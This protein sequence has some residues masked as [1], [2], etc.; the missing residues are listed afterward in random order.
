MTEDLKNIKLPPIYR[1]LDE[2]IKKWEILEKEYHQILTTKLDVFI[3][4]SEIDLRKKILS[5]HI[6]ACTDGL[7][8]IRKANKHNSNNII[9]SRFPGNVK[10]ARKEYNLKKL[11]HVKISNKLQFYS[12]VYFNYDQ[13]DNYDIKSEALNDFQIL[14]S[15]D[16][17]I[18]D[19]YIRSVSDAIESVIHADFE[20]GQ[21]IF[22]GQINE[23]WELIPKL[24]RENHEDASA[25][26][27]ALFE[28]LL[29]G[30]KSPYSNSF[31]PIDHLMNL[32]HFRLPTRLL[33]WTSDLLV[34][35]FFACY[36]E[37]NEFN[38]K[39]GNL[40][41]I[42]RSQYATFDINSSKNNIFKH[43][44]QSD[45]KELFK[46]RLNINDIYV[47]EPVIKN[48]RLRIQDGCF[49]FFPF[50]PLN[51]NEKKFATLHD[52]MRAK[53]KHIEQENKNKENIIP[54]IWIGIK[55]VDK[56]YKNSILKELKE[57]HE[58]S[59]PS[60]FVEIDHIQ[61]VSKYYNGLYG[62][63]KGKASWIKGQRKS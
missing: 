20:R 8:V 63:A 29:L 16:N 11:E 46:N 42:E 43:P 5:S 44:I 58:I 18:E 34:A 55:K 59:K 51:I 15:N 28:T 10:E 56:N 48:P 3:K 30:V 54:K 61:R 27:A 22:R 57:Q 33:D 7:F 17:M 6:I 39:D 60:L 1:I 49:M 32:Q 13:T 24:F 23:E 62:K 45:S 35:L 47:F 31:D 26:E 9:T 52:Y 21:L 14:T 50:A 36:D 12:L 41:V 38:D 2:K 37:I 4:N 19:H 40:F 53:N 25:I